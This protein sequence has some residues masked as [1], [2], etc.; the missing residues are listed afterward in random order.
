MGRHRKANRTIAVPIII[1]TMAGFQG[2]RVR[3]KK[4]HTIRDN[5]ATT[6]ALRISGREAFVRPDSFLFHSVAELE[7]P[8]WFILAAS[9]FVMRGNS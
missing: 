4:A 9:L 5:E 2:T 1:E 8:P 3:E 7:P 6:I